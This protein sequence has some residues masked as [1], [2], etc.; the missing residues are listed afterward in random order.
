[1]RTWVE[2]RHQ[3]AIAG[4]VIH[5]GTGRGIEGAS[6]RAKG[7]SDVLTRTAPDGLFYFL[8]LPDGKYTVEASF[9]GAAG[10]FASGKR[11]AKVS[12]ERSGRILLATVEIALTGTTVKGRITA[13]GRE[14]G[15]RMA[16]VRIKG[17]GERVFSDIDGR[18]VLS[19]IE[20]GNRT[21]LVYAQGF[22]KAFDTVKLNKPG[23]IETKDFDLLPERDESAGSGPRPEIQGR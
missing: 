9:P 20:R 2:A 3:V 15:L 12:R 16:E 22:K 23:A 4:K 14:T 7:P 8:D 1:M 13:K 21:V 19:G 17:S 5:A 11:D 10:R 18:Y 6:V